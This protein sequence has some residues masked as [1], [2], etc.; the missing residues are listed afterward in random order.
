MEIFVERAKVKPDRLYGDLGPMN[1]G[2]TWN[3]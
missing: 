3:F 1:T 2:V